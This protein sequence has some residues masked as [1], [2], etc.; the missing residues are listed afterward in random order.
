[1]TIQQKRNLIWGVRNDIYWKNWFLPQG[2]SLLLNLFCHFFCCI[3]T[4]LF[5]TL[6]LI[7]LLLY[8]CHLW[9]SC[10]LV[11]SQWINPK[12]IVKLMGRSSGFIAVHATLA[13]GKSSQ[14]CIAVYF[15]TI[16]VYL[17]VSY[18]F[19]SHSPAYCTAL[20][21]TLLYYAILVFLF[22]AINY[23]IVFCSIAPYSQVYAAC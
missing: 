18:I 21:C 20:H 7:S 12:G 6:L 17:V 23:S 2:T 10:I 19:T 15:H 1:M 8:L 16:S 14:W 5:C 22:R 13:S 3:S 4:L 11:F 9:Y